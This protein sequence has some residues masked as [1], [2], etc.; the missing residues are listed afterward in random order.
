MAQMDQID[1]TWPNG[2]KWAEMEEMVEMVEM[3]ETWRIGTKVSHRTTDGPKALQNIWYF[4]GFGGRYE[5]L[6]NSTQ[7]GEIFKNSKNEEE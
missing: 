1:K 2:V 5:K 6:V 7:K 3:V 4:H